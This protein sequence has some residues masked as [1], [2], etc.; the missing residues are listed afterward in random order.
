[1]RKLVGV[2][3]IEKFPIYDITVENDHSFE[4]SNGIIAHNSM[5]P[6]AIVSGGCLVE[7]TKIITSTGHKN[8]QDIKLGDSV[9]T[10][11]GENIVTAIWTPETLVEGTPE[12]YKV[13]FDDTSSITCSDTHE[14]LLNKDKDEWG[15]ISNLKAGDTVYVVLQ[16]TDIPY[17][18]FREII[19]IE[20]VGRKPVYDITVE[21]SEHYITWNGVI[22]HNTGI[23][24]S[25]NQIFIITKSQEK[26][27]DELSGWKFTINIEKSRYVK[28]KSKLPFTVLYKSNN[29]TKPGI[30]KWSSLFELALESGHIVKAKMGWYAIVNM[31]TG[32]ISEK[33]YREKDIKKNDGF[34]EKL[35]VDVKFK[36]FI[37]DKFKLSAEGLSINSQTDDEDIDSSEEV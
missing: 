24:Y 30:Q 10:L 11:M 20:S 31:E 9:L 4:L 13:T 15:E 3:E 18:G 2:R 36:Q 34:F 1:M 33:S 16:S 6:K 22:N 23:Y 37:E 35:I 32:E 14:F 5:Y 7:N 27:D 12:C 21:N 25:A 19:N 8:I 29:Q 26:E 17:S 28:E